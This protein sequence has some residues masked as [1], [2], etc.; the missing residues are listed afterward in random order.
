LSREIGL[1]LGWT[2]GIAVKVDEESSV[3]Q[4]VAQGSR[5]GVSISGNRCGCD[6]R[7]VLGGAS[8]LWGS[9]TSCINARIV[10]IS[11][12]EED[13]VQDSNSAV[14]FIL[15]LDSNSVTSDEVGTCQCSNM[16]GGRN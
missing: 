6:S 5:D 7:S 8:S 15:N 13:V 4:S 9:W 11:V 2:R 3:D 1:G 16:T 14:G 12:V 10:K